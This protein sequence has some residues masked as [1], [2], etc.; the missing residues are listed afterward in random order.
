VQRCGQG[1]KANPHPN[2]HCFL[3]YVCIALPCLQSLPADLAF[4]AAFDASQAQV[5]W[6]PE[7]PPAQEVQVARPQRRPTSPHPPLPLLPLAAAGT[8]AA[9]AAAVKRK[10]PAHSLDT[11]AAAPQRQQDTVMQ[12]NPIAQLE[13]VSAFSGHHPGNLLWAPASGET[14]H[15]IVFAAGSLCCQHAASGRP[16][17]PP[18]GAHQGGVCAGAE[19]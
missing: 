9:A 3:H 10:L 11:A 8:A 6:V 19:C 12:P 1:R 13:R 4:T 18:A 16:A 5:L 2:S 15:E 14:P 17:A 7:E